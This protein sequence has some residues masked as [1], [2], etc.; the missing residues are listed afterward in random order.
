MNPTKKHVSVERNA[1][2][3][4][5]IA[6]RANAFGQLAPPPIPPANMVLKF[7]SPTQS[8]RFFGGIWSGEE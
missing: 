1:Q 8:T 2:I 3:T 7:S 5:Q 4:V 6:T